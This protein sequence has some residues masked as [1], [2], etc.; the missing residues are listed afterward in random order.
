MVFFKE[1]KGLLY[2]PIKAKVLNDEILRLL[3]KL[4]FI[5]VFNYNIKDTVNEIS[6]AIDDW[7]RKGEIKPNWAKAIKPVFPESYF[8][9]DA[10]LYPIYKSHKKSGG[11]PVISSF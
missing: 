3:P 5:K 6:E 7:R 1:N 4:G 2:Y 8:Y 11:F 10:V 9:R